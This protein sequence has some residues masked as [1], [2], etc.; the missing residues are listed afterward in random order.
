[1][2]LQTDAEKKRK[3]QEV[4]SNTTAGSVV[5]EVVDTAADIVILDGLFDLAG[6][7]ISGILD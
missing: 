6:D 2:T 4:A 1:M 5:T 7:I 3:Q